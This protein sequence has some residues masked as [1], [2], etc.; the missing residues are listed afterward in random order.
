MKESRPFG[1]LNECFL[2]CSGRVRV[3]L[4]VLQLRQSVP[5]VL[6]NVL[7]TQYSSRHSYQ[8]EIL[9]YVFTEEGEVPH[10]LLLGKLGPYIKCKTLVAQTFD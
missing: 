4:V 8:I 7:Q 1:R 2:T 10:R 6:N 9:E 3:P 5:V